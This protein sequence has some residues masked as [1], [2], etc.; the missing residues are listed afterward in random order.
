MKKDVV[1]YISSCL[2]YQKARVEHKELRW[3]LEQ[4]EIPNESGTILLWTLLLIFQDQQKVA[5][6]F[7]SL[8][9]G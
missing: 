3:M 4:L 6:I 5:M 1:M 9:I 2:T 8:L 7:G